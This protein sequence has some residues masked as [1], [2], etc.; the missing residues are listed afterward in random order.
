MRFDSERWND[1]IF[2]ELCDITNGIN[3]DKESF[4]FGIPIVNYMDVNKNAFLSKSMIKG[5][6]NA[7]EKEQ[8][9]FS[10]KTNDILITRT[11][12]TKQEIAY[13]SCLLEDVEN[14][15]FSGFLL[16]ARP[17]DKNCN[18]IFVVYLLRAI[19]YRQKL[20]RLSTETSRALINSDNLGKLEICLPNKSVQDKI[21]N[22]LML[23]DQRI[24]TQSK[25]IE[26]LETCKKVICNKIFD[27]NTL[28]TESIPLSEIGT[29]KNGYAF[30]S[31]TYTEN[32]KYKVLTIANVSGERYCNET[33]YSTV[34]ELP[35]DIQQH[36]ILKK[37]DIL[38]SLTGNVGRVSYCVGNGYLLNQRVGLF[39]IK[40]GFNKEYLYQVISS[41]LFEKAMQ[42][43]GQGAAQLNIGKNDVESY[44]ISIPKTEEIM[45]AIS[46][47][48][49]AF[50]K[51]IQIEKDILTAYK[52]QKAYL[53]SEMFI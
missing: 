19:K 8:K 47:L 9:T 49:C 46:N 18:A 28:F 12:E 26:D 37:D 7:T 34:N 14:C 53:L 30:K 43:C 44:E 24:N 45:R 35:R 36:Q 52:K 48:L 51:K 15:V 21:A 50:D 39:A 22:F 6:V 4:G 25:I 10:I 13:S 27:N 11:S 38:I 1:Y 40:A 23:I 41:E 31:N 16:R 32:G 33:K 17:K 20:M 5:L 3:K 2:S 42:A 29:L